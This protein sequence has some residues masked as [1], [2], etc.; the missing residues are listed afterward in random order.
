MDC[1]GLVDYVEIVC[2]VQSLKCFVLYTLYQVANAAVYVAA[3]IPHQTRH[4]I[5]KGLMHINYIC[6]VMVGPR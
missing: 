1:G 5:P 3:R 4:L 6:I 2:T